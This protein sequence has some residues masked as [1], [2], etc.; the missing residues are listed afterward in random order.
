VVIHP[1]LWMELERG[2]VGSR[3][4]VS[5]WDVGMLVKATGEAV[6]DRGRCWDTVTPRKQRCRARMGGREMDL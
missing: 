1:A 4:R 5:V 2:K 6:E 3:M